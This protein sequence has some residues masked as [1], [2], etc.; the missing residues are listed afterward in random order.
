[1]DC[2]VTN[3]TTLLSEYERYRRRDYA[4]E[5]SRVAAGGYKASQSLVTFEPVFG[6]DTAQPEALSLFATGDSKGKS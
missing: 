5:L 4:T 3:V 6:F 2:Q 1:M